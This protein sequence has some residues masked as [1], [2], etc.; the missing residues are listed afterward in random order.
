M[1]RFAYFTKEIERQLS[2]KTGFWDELLVK[3]LKPIL[4]S[5][6]EKGEVISDFGIS[7]Y[8]TMH[9]YKGKTFEL[10]YNVL[11]EEKLVKFY[12]FLPVS[13][14]IDW[15][16][17]I[18]NNDMST[19]EISI[20]QIGIDR[21]LGSLKLINMG[22]NTPYKLGKA[23][24]SKAKKE[25]D[26]VRNGQ[27][28]A[29]FLKELGLINITEIYRCNERIQ[30]SLERGDQE[31]VERLVAEKL[32]GFKPI[33]LI[34]QETQTGENEL[35]TELVEKIFKLLEI[36]DCG[37]TTSP[38]R[39]QSVK[40]LTNWVARLAGIPIRRKGQNHVQPYI[41]HIYAT[42]PISI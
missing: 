27:Y 29:K 32:L 40:G 11:F 39:A 35:T 28:T 4:K 18:Q 19:T 21:I 25:R 23:T 26:V 17:I 15:E 42:Q 24:G 37:G 2:D 1:F 31:L 14:K 36:T 41:P 30:S 13:Y 7:I 34:I 10:T 38:R 8:G 12:D 5:L 20:P 33:Q 6:K 9:K 16:G 22:E 3:E